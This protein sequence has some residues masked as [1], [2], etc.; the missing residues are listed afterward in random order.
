MIRALVTLFTLAEALAS[1]LVAQLLKAA[2]SSGAGALAGRCVLRLAPDAV[3]GTR[4]GGGVRLVWEARL[5]S[6]LFFFV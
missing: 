4:Y 3:A 5:R 2:R 6:P 1:R